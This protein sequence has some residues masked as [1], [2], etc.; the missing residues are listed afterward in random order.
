MLPSTLW[1]NRLHLD[2]LRQS[3]HGP[4]DSLL[5]QSLSRQDGLRPAEQFLVPGEKR[6]SIRAEKPFHTQH[7]GLT[8]LQIGCSTAVMAT[9][10]QSPVLLVSAPVHLP[11]RSTLQQH[12]EEQGAA[13]R[14]H[15]EDGGPAPGQVT[16]PR[17]KASVRDQTLQHHY[18][19]ARRHPK[20]HHVPWA[21]SSRHKVPC[22]GKMMRRKV[23][24]A[25][26]CTL[27]PKI[28]QDRTAPSWT[29]VPQGLQAQD[30]PQTSCQGSR[31]SI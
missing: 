21:W 4:A 30:G 14:C 15:G 22:G 1:P 28:R 13:R 29:E 9:I 8:S 26:S 2:W 24:A 23:R 5:V 12:W 7:E 3:K 25:Y 27:H 18:A 10:G 31:R 17:A 20:D 16:N 11:V 6:G 19:G